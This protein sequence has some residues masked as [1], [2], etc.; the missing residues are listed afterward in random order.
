MAVIDPRGSEWVA[1][2]ADQG[3]PKRFET[4]PVVDRPSAEPSLAK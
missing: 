3:N 4:A 1:A 2:P